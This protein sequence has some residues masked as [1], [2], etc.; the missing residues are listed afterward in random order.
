MQYGDKV[1]RSGD[2]G[3]AAFDRGRRWTLPN[4]TIEAEA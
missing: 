3:D 1:V 4:A 2:G